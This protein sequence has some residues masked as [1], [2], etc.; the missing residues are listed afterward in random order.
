M[1]PPH[2]RPKALKPRAVP[3]CADSLSSDSEFANNCN[4]NFKFPYERSPSPP[5]E[6][7]LPPVPPYPSIVK[8]EAGLTRLSAG[9]ALRTVA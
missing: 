1:Y 7:A 5:L 6:L 4:P 3:C 8:Q 9:E 2:P